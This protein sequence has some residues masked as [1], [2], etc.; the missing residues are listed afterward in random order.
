M[1][2]TLR[3]LVADDEALARARLVE[4]LAVAAPTSEIREARDGNETVTLLR[5]WNPDVVF[6]DVQM[7]GRDGLQVVETV[8]AAQMPVT[9]FVTAFDR[10]ALQAFDVA[11]V[12][13]LLKP[14]DDERFRAAWDRAV[15][16]RS[17]RALDAE[18]GRLE[19][20]LAAVR[21][22]RGVP[23][24]DT[25]PRTVDRVIVKRD[26]RSI[27]VPLASVQWVESSGNY[28]TLHAGR[29]R[30]D[31]RETLGRFEATL[32]PARWVRV[33]RR[34]IVAIDAVRELQP[35]FGGDQVMI[36]RDGTRLKV[37]RTH[38]AGVEV[39]LAGRG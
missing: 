9:V 17:L 12:D 3:V 5:D 32:D 33:H 4:L 1:A 39:R 28:V 19:V 20:L 29:E 35:W 24:P 6:L 15:A 21:R 8:G 11:A 34:V 10:F 2:M 26:G 18:V 37:S 22:H 27:V 30:Y 16:Q 14:F 25:T 36:L 38:R 13:Y 7:P 31:V 23:A